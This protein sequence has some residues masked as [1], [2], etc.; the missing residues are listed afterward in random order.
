MELP[1]IPYTYNSMQLNFENR[2]ICNHCSVL[3]HVRYNVQLMY[4]F[5][6]GH[7]NSGITNTSFNTIYMYVTT[8]I[9]KFWIV[10]FL[11]ICQK[12]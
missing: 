10:T 6:Y 7:K 1:T 4:M 3:I 5:L 12:K 9:N 11:H 8:P 2:N